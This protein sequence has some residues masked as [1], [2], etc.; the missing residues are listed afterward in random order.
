[1]IEIV[2][3]IV[4]G[5]VS[6]IVGR[7]SNRVFSRKRGKTHIDTKKLTSIEIEYIMKYYDERLETFISGISNK[8]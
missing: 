3:S 5:L 1:M 6:G 4:S 8:Q 2:G 7:M